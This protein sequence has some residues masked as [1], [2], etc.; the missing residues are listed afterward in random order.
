MLQY[1]KTYKLKDFRKSH[2]VIGVLEGKDGELV[3]E[4]IFYLWDNYTVGKSPVKGKDI[5]FDLVTPEWREICSKTLKFEPN[6]FLPPQT[7]THLP[8]KTSEVD[9]ISSPQINWGQATNSIPLTTSQAWFLT[10][11]NAFNPHHWNLV[12]I[13]EVHQAL[14]P[15]LLTL[16]IHH[17]LNRHDALSLRF[18]QDKSGWQQFSTA[19]EEPI[20]LTWF[21]ISLLSEI[22][23]R[24]MIEATAGSL[25][26]CLNLHHGPLMQIAYFDLGF[27]KPGRLLWIAHH[28]IT[29]GVSNQI[30]FR[31]FQTAYKQLLSGEKVHFPPRTTSFKEWAD[32]QKEFAI[33]SSVL[34]R[35][36][37]EYW[38]ALPWNKIIPL[39]VDYPEAR[40]TDTVA[41]SRTV[42]RWLSLEDTNALLKRIKGLKHLVDKSLQVP[43]VLLMALAQAFAEWTNSP[44][45]HVGMIDHGRV[46]VFEDID[47]LWTVGLIFHGKHLLLDVEGAT[48]LEDALQ[49]VTEQIR[50]VPNRG[51][52]PGLLLYASEDE[53]IV[54]RVRAIPS[55]EV[56]FNYHGLTHRGSSQLLFRPASERIGP[57]QDSQELRTRLLECNTAIIDGKLWL[58]WEYSERLYRH[59]TIEVLMER[60][61]EVLRRFIANSGSSVLTYTNGSDDSFRSRNPVKRD[62]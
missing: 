53:Q 60:Y 48:T 41:S 61:I 26:T 45:L 1:C 6:A 15:L 49:M 59:S 54:Q 62:M 55:Q 47:L 34:R 32:R 11:R 8:E 17:L 25:Q 27:Q 21:D 38:L 7:H 35:E 33:S 29:D 5:I 36:L 31:D 57:T 46:T 42:E 18:M 12:N 9:T 58:A 37:E 30:L 40:A 2:D 16:A 14:D 56:D 13:W 24:Q 39:P 19:F 52:G 20:P 10:E 51:V 50:H 22:E 3:G 44:L 43:D 23:Q 28:L 4:N